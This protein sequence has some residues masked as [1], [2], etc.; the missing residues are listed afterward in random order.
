M[1]GMDGL[2]TPNVPLSWKSGRQP[3][4]AVCPTCG[5][6]AIVSLPQALAD[7]MF[8]LQLLEQSAAG[9]PIHLGRG[10]SGEWW[11]CQESIHSH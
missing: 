3:R 9:C 11:V 6:A 2:T 4:P 10:P 8:T 5:A 7:P 1:T